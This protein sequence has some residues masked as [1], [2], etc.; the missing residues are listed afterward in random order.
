MAI[1]TKLK[2]EVEELK[3]DCV[4]KESRISHLEVKV[5][6]LTS[7][8]KKAKEEAIAAFMKS[9]DFTTRLDRY[10]ASGYE[11][12]CADAKETYPEMDFDSF[13]IPTAIKSSLLPMS[14]EN[15]NVVD[16]ASIEP[17]QDATD[18]SKD[19]PKSGGDAPSG[20]SQ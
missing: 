12:F 5:Q 8:L 1:E 16:D 10:Y 20:L 9:N 11:D 2:N 17:T 18:A 7:P 4:E 14:Y 19:D 3:A 13:K 6:E 15:V